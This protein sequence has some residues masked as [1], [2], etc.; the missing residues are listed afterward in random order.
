[1]KLIEIRN[2]ID[3]YLVGELQMDIV[4]QGYSNQILRASRWTVTKIWTLFEN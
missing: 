2:V 3:E 4:M 1:M